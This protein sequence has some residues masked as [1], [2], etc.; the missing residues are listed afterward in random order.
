MCIALALP[1]STESLF[2]PLIP[3]GISPLAETI[4]PLTVF[5]NGVLF[6]AA[7]AIYLLLYNIIWHKITSRRMFEGTLTHQSVGKKLLT[8]VTGKK[9]SIAELKEKWHVYPMEDFENENNENQPR[10]RLVI[11]PKDKGRD[12]IVGRLSKAVDSGK[13]GGFVWATPGLP[14]L[15]FITFGLIVALLFGDIVWILVWSILG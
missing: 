11:V 3:G 15:I 4:F 2:P 7:T 12:E 14:M 5:S 10:R 13:I 6:A 1:F 9:V 8:L